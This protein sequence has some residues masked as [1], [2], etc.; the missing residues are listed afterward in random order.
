[1][2]I[3][4]SGLISRSRFLSISTL[5]RSYF[6]GVILLAVEIGGIDNVL[7]DD[8]QVFKSRTHQDH[9]TIRAQ[10]PGAADTDFFDWIRANCSGLRYFKSPCSNI[11]IRYFQCA[12]SQ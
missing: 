4:A 12:A 3:L 8:F 11:F 5:G 6:S 10:A 1:M 2:R 7:V 9:G